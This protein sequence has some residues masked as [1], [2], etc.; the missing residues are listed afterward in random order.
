MI[1]SILQVDTF[2]SRDRLEIA[3]YILE[4]INNNNT[5]IKSYYSN[6]LLDLIK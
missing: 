6:A 2:V 4:K 5:N 3:K 1:V